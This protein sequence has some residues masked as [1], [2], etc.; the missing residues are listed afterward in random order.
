MVHFGDGPRIQ[1]VPGNIQRLKLVFS[2]KMADKLDHPLRG[3]AIPRDVKLTESGV[4]GDNRAKLFKVSISK[5][6]V[7][8]GE[9]VHIQE[10][11]G[12]KCQKVAPGNLLEVAV[13]NF[14]LSDAGVLAK[15]LHDHLS[16]IRTDH[17]LFQHQ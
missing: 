11:L 4:C 15:K 6:H 14:E 17:Q 13:N 12:E 9:F 10:L 2:L 7:S 1:A 5:L 8:N 16:T 3:E